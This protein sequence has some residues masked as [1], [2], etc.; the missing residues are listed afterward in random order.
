VNITKIAAVLPSGAFLLALACGGTTVVGAAGS[1]TGAG[2]TASQACADEA[3]QRCTRLQACSATDVQIR[4]GSESACEA[5]EAR[6]CLS[7]LAQPSNGKTP[8]AVEACAQAYAGWTCT[9]YLND[10]NI[11]PACQQK[12]GPFPDGTV[13]AVS[14]QCQTGFCAIAPAASCGTC[15]ALPVA[16]ASCAQLTSCG[17]GLTCTS[18]TMTCVALGAESAACGTGAPC[19]AGLSCVGADAATSTQGIC[20]AAVEALGATC[21]PAQKS[22]PGCDRNAGLVCNGTSKTCQAIVLAAAG[23]PCGDV[24]QQT[25]ACSTEGVCTGASGSTPGT[26]T[27]AAAEGA[28]CDTGSGTTCIEPGRCVGSRGDGGIVGSCQYAGAEMCGG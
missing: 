28:A 6:S 25:A 11:P 24:G 17:A 21:D 23:Q 20:Q 9:D 22:G 8:A 10:E 2:S 3:H 16:G 1:G 27:A 7:T 15:T 18:D 4:Y 5:G 13:C 19:G 12:T 14:G 26:C